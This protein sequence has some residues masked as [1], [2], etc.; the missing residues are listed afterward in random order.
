MANEF[1]VRSGL[2]AKSTTEVT[3]SLNIRG[4]VNNSDINT[5]DSLTQTI[6]NTTIAL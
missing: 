5:S 6:N 1:V 3:D 4:S 2:D